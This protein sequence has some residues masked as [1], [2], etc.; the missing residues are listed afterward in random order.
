[1]TQSAEAAVLAALRAVSPAAGRGTTAD[2]TLR[3]REDLNVGSL[4]LVSIA[5]DLCDRFGADPATLDLGSFI[6]RAETLGDLIAIVDELR[7]AQG[8]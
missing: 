5:V 1:M 7:M 6:D 3:L 8:A 4:A 2:R